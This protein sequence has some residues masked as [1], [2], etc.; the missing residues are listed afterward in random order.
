MVGGGGG[1]R[2]NTAT[3]RSLLLLLLLRPCQFHASCQ[4][5]LVFQQSQSLSISTAD[6]LT[7]QWS[8]VSR[9]PVEFIN[10]HNPLP[11]LPRLTVLV[12][13]I[14]LTLSFSRE[15]SSDIIQPTSSILLS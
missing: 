6:I 11:A 14:L 13:I 2:P 12:S 8:N 1:I 15:R 7:S 5:G 3:S 4:P 9:A 10:P